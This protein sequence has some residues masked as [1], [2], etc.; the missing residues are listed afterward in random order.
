MIHTFFSCQFREGLL[1]T[2][3]PSAF[4]EGQ[5]LDTSNP[6]VANIPFEEHVDPNWFL[7][8]LTGAD[9]IHCEENLGE[10]AIA[11][12]GMYESCQG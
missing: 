9:L 11:S 1:E 6:H 8:D 2:W 7:S 10:W 5:A 3:Q 12:H 4:G